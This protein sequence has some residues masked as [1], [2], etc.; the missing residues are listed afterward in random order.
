MAG[1]AAPVVTVGITVAATVSAA[2]EAAPSRFGNGG[3]GGAGGNGGDHS[4]GNG[5]GG[6]ADSRAH[7]GDCSNHPNLGCRKPRWRRPAW[8][9]CRRTRARTLGTARTTRT[10]AAGSRAGAGQ[11]GAGAAG[12]RARSTG[13][14][15][16]VDGEEP[17]RWIEHVTNDG[18]LRDPGRARRG[19]RPGLTARSRRGGSNTSPTTACCGGAAGRLGWPLWAA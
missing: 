14:T 8:C 10:L 12:S 15:T 17:P 9:W 11:L 3:Q 1:R 2:P 19:L 18:M 4:G 5:I 13:S 16:G 6:P 7:A